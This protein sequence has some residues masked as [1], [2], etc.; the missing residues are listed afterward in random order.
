MA[1]FANLIASQNAEMAKKIINSQRK[2][3]KELFLPFEKM[4]AIERRR[5][6]NAQK[7]NVQ[8]LQKDEANRRAQEISRRADLQHEYNLKYRVQLAP[9]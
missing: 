7:L 8:R 9:E 6:N 1:K 5:W 2:P 3:Q 4:Q